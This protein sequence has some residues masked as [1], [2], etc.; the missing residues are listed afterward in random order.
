MID[1]YVTVESNRIAVESGLPVWDFVS[2]EERPG[3]AGNVAAN[4]SAMGACIGVI[5]V[6]LSKMPE[7]SRDHSYESYHQFKYGIFN[8]EPLRK[9]RIID[10][11][12]KHLARIDDRKKF[13]D[14]ERSWLFNQVLDFDLRSFSVVVFSDYDKGAIDDA[15][16][17]LI[18]SK[19]YKPIYVVDSK[20]KDL[21]I[22]RGMDVLKLN[23]LE[24]ASQQTVMAA[25]P[26]RHITSFFRNV[27]ETR[28]SQGARLHMPYDYD[29]GYGSTYEDFPVT[30]AREVDVTGCGDTHTATMAYCLSRGSDIRE[31]IRLANN[32]SSS[33][34][35]KFGT[36][37][38]DS[39]ALDGLRSFF[40][41]RQEN[42]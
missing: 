5:G 32:V 17:N 40:L 13:L 30:K 23:A 3:G 18:K 36:S 14:E 25:R 12:G 24:F 26:E 41:S 35:Q 29:R 8:A 33:V 7:L 21:S 10:R 15:L 31:A 11:S 42:S 2:R 20:R 16:V 37:I 22:F 6:G 19:C 34:V 27:V 1:E 39:S 38:P 4:L 28:G 9:T